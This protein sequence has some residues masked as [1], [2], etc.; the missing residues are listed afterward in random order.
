M[1]SR[2]PMVKR[3]WMME[4][5]LCVDGDRLSCGLCRASY[6]TLIQVLDGED[7]NTLLEDLSHCFAR[8]G[9]ERVY[10]SRDLLPAHRFPLLGGADLTTGIAWSS[11][12]ARGL[13]R[14]LVSKVDGPKLDHAVVTPPD[15]LSQ[16]THTLPRAADSDSY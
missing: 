9:L 11:A 7:I 14:F 3:N 6:G 4:R 15:A 10:V 16:R 2:I 13:G 8:H 12:N 1:L 5:Q